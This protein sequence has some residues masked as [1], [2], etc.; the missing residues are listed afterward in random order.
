MLTPQQQSKIS[1]RLAACREVVSAIRIA[2]NEQKGIDRLE[3]LALAYRIEQCS[4]HENLI[5]ALNAYNQETDEHYNSIATAW[6]CGSKLCPN[7]LAKFAARN[8]A[9]LRRYINSVDLRRGERWNFATFTIPNPSLSLI[10]TRELVNYAWSLFRKRLFVVSL[11]RGG[12]KSEEFTLT[13]SGFHYH[14][15]TLFISKWFSYQA[16]RAIWTEC[17]ATAFTE[18]GH[19][20]K[21]QQ[22]LERRRRK[23]TEWNKANPKAEPRTDELLR[24]VNKPVTDLDQVANEVCKYITKS[25]SWI[26]M[27]HEYLAESGLVRRWW[28]MFELFG[29][30]VQRDREGHV[31]KPLPRVERTI[32]H[33]SSLSDGVTPSHSESWRL[34]FDKMS[35]EDFCRWTDE[36]FWR[37]VHFRREQIQRRWPQARLFD[38]KELAL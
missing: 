38:A 12:A 5:V 37:T 11:I 15:H 13:T 6:Q 33:T 29:E 7:C 19:T 2:A 23:N 32:V 3:L 4:K 9:K 20:D 14:L 36:Q 25:D 35:L 1:A 8:R 24:I 10:E 18:F 26:K 17:V 22:M 27:S 16:M 21:W 31:N 28:R 30:G 34:K